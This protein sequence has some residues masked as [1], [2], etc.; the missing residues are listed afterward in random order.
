MKI[1]CYFKFVILYCKSSVLINHNFLINSCS[2]KVKNYSD[3]QSP[4][5]EL[6]ISQFNTSFV[7]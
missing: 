3:T 6:K 5:H 7:T 4:L 2:Q 1:I